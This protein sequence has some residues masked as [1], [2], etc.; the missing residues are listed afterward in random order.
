MSD[1][2][3]SPEAPPPKSNILSVEQIQ[4]QVIA[5]AYLAQLK[6]SQQILEGLKDGGNVPHSLTAGQLADRARSLESATQTAMTALQIHKVAKAAR[7]AQEALDAAQAPKAA[8]TSIVT[9]G[10]TPVRLVTP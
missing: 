8:P 3:V 9:P 1:A 2:P 4:E 10:G 7:I 6:L 5:A